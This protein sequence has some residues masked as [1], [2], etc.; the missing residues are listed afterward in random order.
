MAKRNDNESPRRLRGLEIVNK[1]QCQMK[2]FDDS[3]Y[4]VLSQSG[5][6]SY[7]VSKVED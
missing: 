4:E 5:N 1:K 7:L 6:G 3:N 2:R